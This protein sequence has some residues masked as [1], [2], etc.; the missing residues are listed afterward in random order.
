MS[1]KLGLGIGSGTLGSTS[2]FDRSRVPVSSALD[3]KKTLVEEGT[4]FKGSLTSSC[5]VVVR[6]RVEGDIA[7]PSLQVSASGSVHGKVKVTELRSAGELSG[8]FEAD[9]VQLSGQVR[10]KTVIR[11]KTLEVKLAPPNG[12]MELVFG[13]CIIDVGDAPTKEDAARSKDEPASAKD[14][15]GNG[16]KETGASVPPA[17]S[18]PP[19][20]AETK[21]ER[22]AG[23]KSKGGGGD[24]PSSDTDETKAVSPNDVKS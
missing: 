1:D 12:K 11:G 5:P 21:E 6:G 13:E 4:T 23:K 9:V 19:V 20:L 7:A 14:S 17:A 3:D 24:K 15:A 2:S 8:E 18:T 10:D 22:P 16:N